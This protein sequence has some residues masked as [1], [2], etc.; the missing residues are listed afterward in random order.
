MPDKWIV[1]SRQLGLV[2]VIVLLL[3]ATGLQAGEFTREFSFSAEELTLVNLIGEVRIEPSGSADFQVVVQ[4]SGQDAQEDLLKFEVRE[5]KAAELVIQFPV[6]QHRD[7]VYLALDR[8]SESTINFQ[9][10][11]EASW[12]KKLFSELGSRKIKVR[13]S[14]KGLEMWADVTIKVPAGARFELRSGVGEVFASNVE[15]DL[16]LDTHSGAVVVEKVTGDVLVDTGSGAVIIS[17]VRGEVNID[18][19]SGAVRLADCRGDKVHVDTG[20]GSVKASGISSPK[21]LIDTGSG[22]VYLQLDSLAE[23]KVEIDTGSGRVEL[24]LP[25]DASAHI[26]A[27][28]GSGGITTRLDGAVIS[29]SDEK[30]LSL[31]VGSGQARV[32]LDTGSGSITIEQN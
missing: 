32:N 9:Q 7:Y 21:T 10:E 18:T 23:G 20:S 19:G 16:N 13:G 3:A 15:A 5:R 2:A 17:A 4:V 26:S 22:S 28:T 24:I 27:D 25:E 30:E 31:Q 6:D 1:S 11:A 8:G 12:L 29:R 14:G